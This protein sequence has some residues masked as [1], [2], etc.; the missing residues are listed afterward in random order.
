MKEFFKTQLCWNGILFFFGVPSV[1]LQ[2]AIDLK[3]NKDFEEIELFSFDIDTRLGLLMWSVLLLMARLRHSR[4]T[5]LTLILLLN[6]GAR[7]TQTIPAL[8]KFVCLS[9]GNGDAKTSSSFFSHPLLPFVPIHAPG[10]TFNKM[11]QLYQIEP[12]KH[13]WSLPLTGGSDQD[14]F[15]MVQY[16]DEFPARVWVS[17]HHRT[18]IRSIGHLRLKVWRCPTNVWT[19]PNLKSEYRTPPNYGNSSSNWA[20]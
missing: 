7:N 20:V 12:M 5:F 13:D 15:W 2:T 4:L 11:N 8:I 3:E 10:A 14:G 18:L 9:K 16:E 19:S 6:G 17:G 1:T